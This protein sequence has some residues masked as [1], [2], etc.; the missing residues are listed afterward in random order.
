MN[1]DRQRRQNNIIVHNLTEDMGKTK[2]KE[3]VSKLLKEETGRK[4]ENEIL[5]MFRIGKKGESSKPRPLLIKF[6]SLETKNMVLDNSSRL[7]DSESF[8]KV[9]LSLNLSKEDR[10]DRKKLLADKLKEVNK[11]GGSKKSVVRIRGQPG[12]FHDIAYRRRAVEWID[13]TSFFYSLSYVWFWFWFTMN[14]SCTVTV[15]W[16][17]Y[18]LHSLS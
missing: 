15:I 10:E 13:R 9:I 1:N 11:K 2:Q 4:I 7:K 6:E 17:S 3:V 16:S 5:E 14:R 8:N 18:K 12:A